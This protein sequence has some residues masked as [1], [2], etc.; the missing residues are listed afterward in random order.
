M[1][2]KKKIPKR[3]THEETDKLCSHLKVFFEHFHVVEAVFP[4]NTFS[5]DPGRATGP[6]PEI[7]N[8][9]DFN[10]EEDSPSEKAE[11]NKKKEEEKEG[12]DVKTGLWNYPALSKHKPK[13]EFDDSLVRY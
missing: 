9:D 3:I 11:K 7:V 5:D 8:T 12:F 1:R 10:L 2:N 6:P 4:R 13:R